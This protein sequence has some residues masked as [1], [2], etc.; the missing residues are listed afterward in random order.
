MANVID[1]KLSAELDPELLGLFELPSCEDV[2]L[3]SPAKLEI[4]L[5]TGGSLKAITDLSKAIP[6]DCSLSAS[7]MLQLMPFLASIECLLKLL[8]LI[9]PLID[10]IKG[11]PDLPTNPT[12]VLNALPDFIKAAEEVMPCVLVV[13]PGAP[14]FP[15]I[16]DLLCLILKI[17]NCLISQLKTIFDV[18]SG[19]KLRIDV[20]KKAN[21]TELQRILNCAMENAATSAKQMSQSFEPVMAI[22]KLA[23]PIFKLTGIPVPPLDQIQLPALGGQDDLK[24]LQKTIKA[25]EGARDIIKAVMDSEP[26]KSLGGGEACTA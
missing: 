8:G 19:L 12:K 9:G 20:A 21:N 23:G 26:I 5:P 15:F 16:R 24:D 22:L 17:L 10:V 3:P 1:V 13:V 7:L 14:F 11:L 6:N 2:K 4:N 18:M 25:L